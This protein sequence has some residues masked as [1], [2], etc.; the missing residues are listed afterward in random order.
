[1]RCLPVLCLS[2][3]LLASLFAGRAA[4]AGEPLHALI[5]TTQGVY[6]NYR[7]QTWVLAHRIAN[8]A[9]VRFDVSLSETERWRTT[10]FAQG[11][12]VII[13]NMCMA[14]NT[15]G[16][17]IANM[18]RQTEQLG[19]P[20]LVIHCTMHSFRETE[21]WWPMLGLKSA[22]HEPLRAL[23]MTRSEPHPILSG[24]PENWTLTHDELY[25]NLEFEGQPLLTVN[26]EDG[27]QHV[28]AWLAYP[29]GTP[30]FGTTLGHSEDTV[31]NPPFQRMLANALLYVTGNLS[32]DGTPR[33]GMEGDSDGMDIFETFSAP[34]GVKFLGDE[35]YDCARRKLA[36]AAAPCYLGCMLNPLLWNEAA[37]ACKKSCEADLPSP[38]DLIAMCDAAGA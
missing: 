21:L 32:P 10:D 1:M 17:L 25:I 16:E 14:D 4:Q 2:L 37:D 9:N 24:I 20:A 3:G 33:P 18:R 29:G 34:R 38:D 31:R 19:V 22:A 27:R 13:Y 28:V 12:D 15:D 5:V 36:F 26:G 35:G 11:Y 7:Q 30:V 23:T 8:H 6:H